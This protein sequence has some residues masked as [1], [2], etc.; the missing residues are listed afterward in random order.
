MNLRQT[1]R[2]ARFAQMWGIRGAKTWP[3]NCLLGLTRSCRQMAVKNQKT[4]AGLASIP[5]RRL[6]QMD[7][8]RLVS[9]VEVIPAAKRLPTFRDHLNHHFAAR[10]F[11]NLRDAVVVRLHVQLDLLVLGEGPSLRKPHVDARA[12]DNLVL[13][14]PGYF[15]P[16]PGYAGFLVLLLFVLAVRPTRRQH[17]QPEQRRQRKSRCLPKW[18]DGVCFS[19]T[20]SPLLAAPPQDGP[21]AGLAAPP[22]SDQPRE[23]RADLVVSRSGH[24]VFLFRRQVSFDRAL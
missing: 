8:D 21:A 9:F 18:E 16:Q 10:D 2:L 4:M 6:L 19:Q 15:D 12:F 13:F 7:L 3:S 20:G 23:V 1:K 17:G 14:S 22:L 24:H 5:A 11:R